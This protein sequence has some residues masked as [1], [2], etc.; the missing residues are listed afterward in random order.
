MSRGITTL[1]HTVDTADKAEKNR[2]KNIV[3]LVLRT[4]KNSEIVVDGC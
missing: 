3:S 1:A 4:G 2:P